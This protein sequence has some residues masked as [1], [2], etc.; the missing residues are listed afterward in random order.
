MEH[1]VRQR[2]LTTLCV[3]ALIA[4]GG[5]RESEQGR[6]LD[7]AKGTYAGAPDQRLSAETRDALVRRAE[8]Q[9]F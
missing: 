7:S 2:F 9:R 8:F 4:L 5:C 3:L 6:R 1:G